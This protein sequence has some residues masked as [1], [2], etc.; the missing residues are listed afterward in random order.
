MHFEGGGG[1][2]GGSVLHVS[3]VLMS[4]PLITIDQYMPAC[5]M[6]IQSLIYNFLHVCT[7]LINIIVWFFVQLGNHL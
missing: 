1:G 5:T 4:S 3:L 7:L 2:E 6:P